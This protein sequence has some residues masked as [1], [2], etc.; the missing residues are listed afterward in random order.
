MVNQLSAIEQLRRFILL[1]NIRPMR[2]WSSRFR[3]ASSNRISWYLVKLIKDIRQLLNLIS[4]NEILEMLNG[5]ILTVKFFFTNQQ[6]CFE[7]L[8]FNLYLT[9]INKIL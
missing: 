7:F 4:G 1:Q 3:I 5:K 2:N 6:Y 9:G 8:K